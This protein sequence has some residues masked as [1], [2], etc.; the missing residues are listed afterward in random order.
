MQ[1]GSN[2]GIGTLLARNWWTVAL[3]GAIAILFGL[4]LL[5][6]PTISLRVLV[7]LFGLFAIVGGAFTAIVMLREANAYKRWWLF[8][9]EGLFGIAAGVIA[10]FWPGITGLIL[11]Y[12]IAAWAIVTG[13]FE[14]IVAFQLRQQLQ[15]E[16]LLV[17][18]G[19][20]SVVFGVLL[21]VWPVAGA[22]AILV[23]LGAYAIF[24]GVMLL[25][26]AYR[27]RNWHKQEPPTTL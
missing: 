22:L 9:L 26:V 13:L 24:Y 5:I 1:P 12:L 10:L 14:I 8:L 27:L 18:A 4:A 25:I 11:L 21:T 15:G 16:W 17:L 20:V 23:F 3:R 7:V 6:W 19:I 2:L